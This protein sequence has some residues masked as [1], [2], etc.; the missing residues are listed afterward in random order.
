MPLVS[1]MFSLCSKGPLLQVHVKLNVFNLV[2]EMN[3]MS[4][5]ILESHLKVSDEQVCNGVFHCT[6]VM[7]I[8]MC[9]F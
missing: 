1:A 7:G 4:Y 2:A 6:L 9:V 8:K 5:K 3:E